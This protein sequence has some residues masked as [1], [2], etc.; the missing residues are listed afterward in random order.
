MAAYRKKRIQYFHTYSQREYDR[1]VLVPDG[2][3]TLLKTKEK[4]IKRYVRK[5]EPKLTKIYC[6]PNL[7]R[8]QTSKSK[9]I[10]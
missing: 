6:E 10:Q 8:S 9:H 3:Y 2:G 1:K 4:E 7:T 5:I